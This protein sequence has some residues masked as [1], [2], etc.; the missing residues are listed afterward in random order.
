LPSS[1]DPACKPGLKMALARTGGHFVK[2]TQAV[3]KITA[4]PGGSIVSRKIL[5]VRGLGLR[6]A[7][8]ALAA[9]VDAG[10]ALRE[11]GAINMPGAPN[12]AQ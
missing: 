8:D 11:P 10:Y 5:D 2:S 6:A 12:E 7:Y 3:G 9:L 1:K 4:E